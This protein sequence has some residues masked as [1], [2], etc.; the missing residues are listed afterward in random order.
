MDVKVIKKSLLENRRTIS[1]RKG[2]ANAILYG[3]PGAGKTTHI[4]EEIRETLST[5]QDEV[6]LFT[7][8]AFFYEYDEF[9]ENENF[10]LFSHDGLLDLT[11][12]N[13]IYGERF[14]E[15]LTS[16]N[17]PVWVYI[18]NGTMLSKKQINSCESMFIMS[19]SF[20][21]I[22]TLNIMEYTSW[23]DNLANNTSCHIFL[24]TTEDA[25][26]LFPN[27]YLLDDEKRYLKHNNL[28]GGPIFHRR[29][30]IKY[31][32]LGKENVVNYY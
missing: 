26:E 31:L 8:K 11:V 10:H 30:I 2:N 14:Q 17:N 27:F 3:M 15:I 12:M 25:L 29:S 6:F 19:R 7:T 28:I 5:T 21:L 20:H 22:L 1:P 16:L 9:M 13:S 18:D 4:K 24:E 23:I 32:E